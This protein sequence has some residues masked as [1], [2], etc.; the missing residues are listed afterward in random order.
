MAKLTGDDKKKFLVEKLGEQ[1][2]LLDKSIKE[3]ASGDHA[4]AVR[5]AIAMRVL[6]HETGS[7]K[8]L[9]GQLT[10]NYLELEILDQRPQKEEKVPPGIHKAAVS[11]SSII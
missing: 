6:L 2:H 10:P 7:S 5:L 1:R 9:L 4:E 8:P 3:F 11:V